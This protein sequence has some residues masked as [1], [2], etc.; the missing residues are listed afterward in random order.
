VR[1]LQH[2]GVTRIALGAPYAEPVVL[3]CK[4]ALE[5]HGLQV[6][7]HAN[8]PDVRN[9]YVDTDEHSAY[10]VA[11]LADCDEAEA[12]YLAGV[13]MPTVGM[14]KTIEQDRGKPV[15]SSV[16][17]SVWNALRLAGVPAMSP[18]FGRLLEAR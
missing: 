1:G 18:G 4:E 10:R 7:R 17:A 15:V 14:L 2:L 5:S 6:V 12:I 9:I 3:Q 13:G 8:V 16:S 11:R